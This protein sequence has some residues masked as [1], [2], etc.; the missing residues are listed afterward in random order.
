MAEGAL[1]ARVSQHIVGVIAL[2]VELDAYKTVL[3]NFSYNTSQCV[4]LFI[5]Q[6]IC[7]HDTRD[8]VRC[9]SV[10]VCIV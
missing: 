8:T 10:V 1:L 9:R 7:L 4:F 2:Q 5:C 3:R 6:D